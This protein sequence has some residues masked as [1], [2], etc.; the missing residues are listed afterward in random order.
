[1]WLWWCIRRVWV[2]W[3]SLCVLTQVILT[4]YWLISSDTN[5]W[6]VDIILILTSDWLTESGAGAEWEKARKMQQKMGKTRQH[7]ESRISEITDIL[8]PASPSSGPSAPPPRSSQP[9]P[10]PSQPPPQQQQPPS[11]EE[12]M[13]PP[14]YSQT[15]KQ[16]NNSGAMRRSETTES[17]SEQGE[18]LFSIPGVQVR[19]WS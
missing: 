3:T 7:V 16:D 5:L 18:I 13:K 10:R 1:M 15:V 17:L 12:V 14:S 19:P 6:L 9:P 8:A 4:Y 11:Y 2:S